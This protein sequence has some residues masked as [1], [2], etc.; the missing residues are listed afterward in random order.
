MIR[1]ETDVII[2]G[3]GAAG[4]MSAVLLGK[5]KKNIII[6]ERQEKIG[7]KLLIT[8]NGKCNY[9]NYDQNLSCYRSKEFLFKQNCTFVKQVLDKFSVKETIIFFQQLGI[10]PKEKNGYLYPR[11]EQ[12]TSIIEAFL[13]ALNYYKVKVKCK[14]DVKKIRVEQGRFF[15]D[16][17]TYT[18][19]SK[20]VILACGGKSF[21]KSEI[22]GGY[23]LASSLG[24]T[25]IKPAPALVALHSVDKSWKDVT[26]VRTNVKL[27]LWIEEK[28]ICQES[29]ELQLTQYGI[30]GIPVFQISHY[31][32]LG[33]E[34]EKAVEVE[35]DFFPELTVEELYCLFQVQ[36]EINSYKTIQL[37][38]NGFFPK[39][40]SQF[41]LN[42]LKIRLDIQ[43]KEVPENVWRQLINN[44]KYFRTKII[45]TN[46]FENAQVTSGGISISEI[47]PSTME[48]KL[49]KNLYFAGEMID[50][51]GI[52]GGYNLQWAWSCGY[53]AGL[54][55]GEVKEE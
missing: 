16:T 12:A 22:E 50:I 25:I 41:L 17:D 10:F 19:K 30:S 32:S 31:A 53:I 35:I 15:I 45:K 18:Y 43:V 37:F 55:A 1:L 26:G 14:Q 9:T 34:Q 2:I 42:E 27:T 21:P 51:D 54:Y 36:K 33:L 48:S 47:N 4:L 29:G 46:G 38:C 49:V 20:K 23:A 7:K 6:L 11:S 28:Q 8:G 52:C 3:A 39:K 13:N 24:H 5:Y 44:I 40:L